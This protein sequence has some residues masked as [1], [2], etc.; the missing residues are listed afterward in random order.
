MSNNEPP[1]YINTT[2]PPGYHVQGMPEPY[3]VRSWQND[4]SLL[5]RTRSLTH[6]LGLEAA[7]IINEELLSI[8]FEAKMGEILSLIGNTVKPNETGYL[9][10]VN[11]IINPTDDSLPSTPAPNWVEPV[12]TGTEPLDALAESYLR[13][14]IRNL[15]AE[16]KIKSRY[17][18]CI[19][20]LDEL[21]FSIIKEV[22][23][24]HLE[25]Q[26][27]IEA[28]R[29][30][31]LGWVTISN[32]GNNIEQLKVAE[33]WNDFANRRILQIHKESDRILVGSLNRQFEASEQRFNR[34]YSDYQVAQ[35]ELAA[36]SQEAKLLSSISTIIS[37][38]NTGLQISDQ[39]NSTVS[40][41]NE[42]LVRWN[43]H[44]IEILNN[45]SQLSRTTFNEELHRL[46]ELETK[47]NA[48]WESYRENPPS[49]NEIYRII[50]H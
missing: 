7:I 44:Q 50:L 5:E 4:V 30:S 8:A 46:R 41:N 3:V 13:P 2:K 40:E 35:K 29:R 39:L 14:E 23:S 24:E 33:R 22:F 21:K 25:S 19:R 38:I 42:S 20:N 47:L 16:V 27:K 36:R 32:T 34:A 31:L 17:F 37:L 1:K 12:G 18:W 11:E 26:A 6:L 9:I 10:R 43:E 49:N 48:L 28:K 15:P 45:A